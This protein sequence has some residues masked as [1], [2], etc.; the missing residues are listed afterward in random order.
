[1]GRIRS[2]KPEFPQSE[3]MGNVSRDARLLF[4]QLWTIA[5]DSG[6]L[7]AAS[8]M[9]ASLLYPY[10]KDAGDLIDGWLDELDRE[11]CIFRYKAE[12]QSY[13]EIANWLD[14]QKIDH[15]TPSKIPPFAKPRECSRKSREASRLIGREGIGEEGKG[16]RANDSEKKTFGEFANVHLLPLEHS[17]LLADYGPDQTRAIVEKL[18]QYKAAKGKTYKSDMAAIRQWVIDSTGVQKIPKPEPPCP[19]CGK[20]LDQGACMNRDCPQ[21]D[22]EAV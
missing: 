16:S 13:I 14:H 12:G 5:D 18:S 3:S 7:R 2:I 22:R 9:L 6:R 19:H 20:P 10:D 8:R 4:I 11:K 15:P 1:M 21:Y 17:S